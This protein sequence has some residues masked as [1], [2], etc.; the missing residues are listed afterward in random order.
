MT[1]TSLTPSWCCYYQAHIQ[2]E[3]VWF[4]VAVLRS[5]EHIA[6]DRTYDVATSCFEFFVPPLQE[7]LFL[8]VFA[9]FEDEG[10]VKNLVKL[11]NRFEALSHS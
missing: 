4:F 7:E 8:K 11:P 10:I 6:F 9:W 3:K 2:R 1:S 5:Q